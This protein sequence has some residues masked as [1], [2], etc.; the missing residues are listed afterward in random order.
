MLKERVSVKVVPDLRRAK[1]HEKY[2][3][4]LRITFKGERKYY[5]TI[6]DATK[7]EWEEINSEAVKGKLRTI[8]NEI[9]SLEKEIL[10]SIEKIHP[11]SFQKFEKKFLKNRQEFASLKSAFDAYINRL[12]SEERIGTASAYQTALNSLLLYKGDIKLNEITVDYLKGFEKNLIMD[13][14]S[15]TTVGIYLRP[16]RAILNLAK[17]ED[18][19]SNDEYPFGKRKYIIPTGVNLKKA[20]DIKQIEAIFNYKCSNGYFEERAKD[21]WIFSYLANGM[22]MKDIAMIKRK[23]V[24]SDRITFTREKTKLTKRTQPQPIVFERTQY[25]NK[26]IKQWQSK[27]IDNPDGYLFDIISSNDN[28]T[29]IKKKVNQFTQVTNKWMKRIGN[30]LGIETKL[31]TYVARHSFAT[32]LLFKGNAPIKHIS[33]KLGHSS[34]PITEKYIASCSFE[35]DK[36]Y[37]KALTNF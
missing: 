34:V 12:K 19:I 31:T 29:E 37:S 9:S 6:Y 21:F 22:N 5:N 33:N 18:I 30:D 36:I 14:L 2:P 32:I 25:I 24:F 10:A 17:S 15:Y 8:R 3:L 13:G 1:L 4:K 35:E 26:I 16:L 11:F 27:E 20:L 28:A 23:N 7:K